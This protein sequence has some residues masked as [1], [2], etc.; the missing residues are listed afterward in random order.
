MRQKLCNF[1]NPLLARFNLSLVEKIPET[2]WDE[3]LIA[4]YHY[5]KSLVTD[6]PLD[7][8]KR[9]YPPK[10]FF[11][12]LTEW[13]E[14]SHLLKPGVTVCELGPGT[15]RFTDLYFHICQKV[16]LVDVSKKI[17][18]QIL[19]DKYQQQTHIEILHSSDCR[20]ST[21]P[22]ASVDLFFG[23]GVFS[24]L[25]NEQMLGYLDEGMRILKPGGKLLMEY[26]SFSAET[27]WQ[28]FLS[29]IPDD[30]SNSIFRYHATE[31]LELL[32]RRVGY[33]LVRSVIDKN[34]LN[35]SYLELQKPETCIAYQSILQS[36]AAKHD[37]EEVQKIY[38]TTGIA[39]KITNTKCVEID[40]IE[41]NSKV[42][43]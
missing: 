7:Y 11:P 35:G 18:E 12:T 19:K 10:D 37:S 6:R 16:Y 1:L 32:A 17:C 28:R 24:H 42:R 22:G 26:Q 4:H 14:I 43:V 9:E 2:L 5:Q 21:I 34:D 20:M 31:G 13:E 23:F 25:D 38:A 30:F 27:G 3:G 36:A 33:V 29:R 41:N 39:Q 8:K 40:A 15:G